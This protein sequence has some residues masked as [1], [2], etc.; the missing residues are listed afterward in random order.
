MA[1]YI[2][3]YTTSTI[4][5]V[6]DSVVTV[7]TDTV[8]PNP[9]V[10]I[11]SNL[12]KV[13]SDLGVSQDLFLIVYLVLQKSSRPAPNQYVYSFNLRLSGR[14]TN[15]ANL[16][17]GPTGPTGFFA[18]GPQGPTGPTALGPTGDT[19]P[20]GI[21]GAGS[22]FTLTKA[23]AET[24]VANDVIA[25]NASG[26]A[27]V[28]DSTVAS[29]YPA[30]GISTSVVGST[31]TVVSIGPVGGFSGL[32]PGDTYFLSSAGTIDSAPPDDSID[33]VSQIIG[34]AQSASIL[35]ANVSPNL[36]KFG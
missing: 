5:S 21:P 24:I 28:A 14:G 7:T 23:S 15:L 16:F 13:Y 35:I 22:G 6:I 31:V 19:G 4:G 3:A 26:E 10:L 32:V 2:T 17:V 18:T 11:Y 29:R 12:T 9:S 34:V 33:E 30:V 1:T 36:I 25:I 20:Q 8:S 27:I